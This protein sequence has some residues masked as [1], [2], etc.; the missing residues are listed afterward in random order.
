[1]KTIDIELLN[2]LILESESL[3][4]EETKSIWDE[5]KVEP[6]RWK[7]ESNEWGYDS[8]WVVAILGNE[9]IWFNDKTDGFNLSN[10]T[11]NGYIDEY[12]EETTNLQNIM[13]HI[14]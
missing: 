10:F 14:L 5:I 1:M 12:W 3:M 6:N 7:E 2:S 11:E 8:F 9:V 4:N 13:W